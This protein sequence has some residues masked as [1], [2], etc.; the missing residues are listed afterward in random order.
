MAKGKKSKREAVLSDPPTLAQLEKE[1]RRLNYRQS[2]GSALRGTIYSLVIV[3]AAAVL[4]ATLILPV[5]RIYGESMSPTLENSDIVVSMRGS[6]FERGDIVAFYYNNKI[7]VKRVIALPGEWIEIDEN[8]VVKIN[9][10]LFEEPYLVEQAL[11]EC[12]LEFPYQVPDSRLFL[13]GDHR[14][15]SVDSRSS[16]VGCVAQE[17]VVGRLVWRVWPL[18]SFGRVGKTP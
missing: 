5:L 3:A 1:Y 15:V 6:D 13:M 9:G 18:A 14:S 16:S 11:G 10:E 2:Y 17:Q 7:L 12:D 4:V 8:G